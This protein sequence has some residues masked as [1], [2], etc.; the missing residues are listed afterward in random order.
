MQTFIYSRRDRALIK[1]YKDDPTV[2]IYEEAADEFE[3]LITFRT[4][5]HNAKEGDKLIIQSIQKLGYKASDVMENL[6]KIVRK[7]I[8]LESIDECITN[9][10]TFIIVLKSIQA[11]LARESDFVG[12]RIKEAR[13]VKRQE[14]VKGGRPKYLT[15][16]KKAEIRDLYLNKHMSQPQIADKLNISTT[17]VNNAIHDKV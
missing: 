6:E 13:E 9:E 5:L 14:G 8:L 2:H 11:V 12:N 15:D 4:V 1:K 17:T 7:K 10:V 16:E 3:P